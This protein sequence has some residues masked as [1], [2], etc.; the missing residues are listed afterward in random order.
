[1]LADIIKSGVVEVRY[2]SHIYRQSADS[3]I[4]SNAL[5]INRGHMREINNQ[6]KDFFVMSIS[7]FNEVAQTV[8]QLVTTRLPKFTGLPSSEIQVLGAL[9]SGVAGV[10]NLNSLLQQAL[11]PF[12]YGKGELQVGKTSSVWGTG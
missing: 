10:E 5:L 12:A 4:V 2:L 8:V 6:S 9:K 7:D 3:L 1:M 11:N